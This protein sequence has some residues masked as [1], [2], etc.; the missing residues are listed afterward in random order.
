M[1][2]TTMIKQSKPRV[3]LGLRLLGF[4]VI[5]AMLMVFGGC[6]PPGPPP[7]PPVAHNVNQRLCFVQYTGVPYNNAKPNVDGVVLGDLGWTNSFRYVFENG[8]SAADGAVQG[9]KDGDDVYLSFEVNKDVTFDAEDVIVIGIDPDNTAG[10]RR[11]L[12]IFPFAAGT[13]GSATNQPAASVVYQVGDP[14]AWGVNQALPAGTDIKVAYASAGQDSKWAVE[15]K[16]PSAGF[17]IPPV[18]YFGLYFAVFKIN[19]GD[20]SYTESRYPSDATLTGSPFADLDAGATPI[21]DKWGNATKGGATCNGVFFSSSDIA[22]NQIPSNVISLN[23]ANVFTVTVH[24][25]SKNTG[26][27]DVPANGILATFK[28][29]NFGLGNQWSPIPAP[30]NPT[31]DPGVNIPA[32]GSMPISTGQWLPANPADYDT[33]ATRHQCVL[34]ELDS[35]S[36][37]TFFVNR[38]TWNNMNFQTTASP[39]DD[40]VTIGTGVREAREPEVE[41][42]LT[43][44]RYNVDRKATWASDIGTVSKRADRSYVLKTKA[45]QELPVKLSVTPPNVKIPST[46]TLVPG[47]T[48]PADRKFV[49][50]PV[51]PGD[52]LTL[53]AERPGGPGAISKEAAAPRNAPPSSTAPGAAPGA[54]HTSRYDPVGT[55][56]GSWDGFEKGNFVIGPTGSLK[57]PAQA[58]VLCLAIS[59]PRESK[60]DQT[61]ED[62]IVQTVETEMSE[63]Y[64]DLTPMVSRDPLYE[65]LRLPT[66][67]NLPTWI[68]CGERRTGE[69]VQINGKTFER[70]ESLGC[71]GYALRR[72]GRE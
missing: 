46:Y 28:I 58:S 49:R 64:T 50:I 15:M 24:N 51:K 36:K 68:L 9:I 71:Y 61:Q 66:G 11:R 42:V 52:L 33:P 29:A 6:P 22:T 27:A 70:R 40:V 23:H 8:T 69:K 45:G 48:S 14:G 31:P 32:N 39:F 19:G 54:T 37:D 47:T 65:D 38:S 41:V 17:G 4:S 20:F 26:G 55:L 25:T 2:N 10:N 3:F 7:P 16:L 5:G 63:I 13:A 35:K 30:N 34:V 67:I 72:I 44:Y 53:I 12:R 57:V 59:Y 21:T 62:L 43:E 1:E 60:P 18:N 56:V